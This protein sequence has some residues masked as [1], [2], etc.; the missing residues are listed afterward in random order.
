MEVTS[1][2]LRT[3]GTVV[4]GQLSICLGNLAVHMG[5]MPCL[6]SGCDYVAQIW[7]VRASCR[8]LGDLSG[9]QLS[10]PLVLLK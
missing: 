9:K 4:L 6:N 2:T 7:P 1:L 10:S 3:Q 5:L 8:P